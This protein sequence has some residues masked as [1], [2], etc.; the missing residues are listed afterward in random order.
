MT[1]MEKEKVLSLRKQGVRIK[2]IASTIGVS[3]NTIKTFLRRNTPA[4]VSD[5]VADI[6][7]ESSC[8]PLCGKAVSGKR[9]CTTK[10]RMLWWRLHP[11]QTKGMVSF[12]CLICGKPFK[13][14]PSQKRKYCSKAC[15]GK[16]CRG[17][18]YHGN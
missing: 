14:Y 16:S 8:C 2:E 7:V 11:H 3:E 15:Y 12:E 18:K 10:C 17:E 1:S 4:V 9:F 13:S 5:T 6:P